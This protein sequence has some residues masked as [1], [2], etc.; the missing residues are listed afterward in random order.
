MIETINIS[1]IKNNKIS[2]LKRLISTIRGGWGGGVG[3]V[4]EKKKRPLEHMIAFKLHV[5]TAGKVKYRKE[6]I[7]S[8]NIKNAR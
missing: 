6:F 1:N 7:F 5:I 8:G 2:Q 4:V 3:F